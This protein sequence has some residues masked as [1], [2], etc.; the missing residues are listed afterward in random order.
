MTENDYF[1]FCEKLEEFGNRFEFANGNIYEKNA[2]KIIPK[3]IVD[4]VLHANS[5]NFSDFYQLSMASFR[6]REIVYNIQQWLIKVINTVLFKVYAENCSVF[7]SLKNGY[8]VPDVVVANA[9]KQELTAQDHLKNPFMVLEV[10]SPPT[11]EIDLG[12]KIN[13]YKS[14][15]NLKD[16]IIV[17]Q[18]QAKI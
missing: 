18:D 13:E 9:K 11:Q 15:P 1:I 6:H 7:I 14:I 10:L 2:G 5:T 3:Q 12:A 17:W 8:R 4:L 16:Y